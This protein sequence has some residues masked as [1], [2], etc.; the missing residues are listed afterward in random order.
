MLLQ[1]RLKGKHPTGGFLG[2]DSSVSAMG[3]ALTAPPSEPAAGGLEGRAGAGS[4]DVASPA[5]SAANSDWVPCSI[6][7]EFHVF[8][9]D[10]RKT[11]HLQRKHNFLE[12]FCLCLMGPLRCG[13][14]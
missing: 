13:R 3:S 7:P 11:N 12:D 6:R 14:E 5:G 1:S 9:A 10:E 8:R 4:L 2:S